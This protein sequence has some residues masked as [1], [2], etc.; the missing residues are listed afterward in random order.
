MTAMTPTTST[1]LSRPDEL[2]AAGA[3]AAAGCGW[4]SGPHSPGPP[5]AGG[6]P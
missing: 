5:E 3:A 1:S 2:V 4:Y 6:A